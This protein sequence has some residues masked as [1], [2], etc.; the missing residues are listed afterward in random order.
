[1]QIGKNPEPV[2]VCEGNWGGNVLAGGFVTGRTSGAKCATILKGQPGEKA[3]LPAG[4]FQ[5]RLWGVGASHWSGCASLNIY[6][7]RDHPLIV[8]K[9]F[10]PTH[11]A[12]SQPD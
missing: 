4:E 3:P 11:P 2:R 1:M 8:S 12:I 10:P 9:P 5:A 7:F 6:T